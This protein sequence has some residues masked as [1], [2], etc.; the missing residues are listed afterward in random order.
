MLGHG[1]CRNPECVSDI[2][3]SCKNRSISGGVC[4]DGS[5]WKRI[6][7]RV[8]FLEKMVDKSIQREDEMAVKSPDRLMPGLSRMPDRIR[9]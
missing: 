4:A 8:V 5:T 3:A 9:I 7:G 1:A 2:Y 6:G